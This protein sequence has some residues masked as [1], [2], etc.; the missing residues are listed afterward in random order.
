MYMYECRLERKIFC[1]SV[2]QIQINAE[3]THKKGKNVFFGHT[4]QVSYTRRQ[5]NQDRMIF[6]DFSV[7]SKVIFL[8]FCKGHFLLKS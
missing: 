4:Y 1:C 5:I 3:K 7:N 6:S 2:S 8:K